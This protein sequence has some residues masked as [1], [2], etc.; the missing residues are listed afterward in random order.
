MSNLKSKRILVIGINFMPELTGIGKYTGE[1]VSWLADN[2]YDCSVVTAFPYY[3]YWKIQ[4][5]Y[6]AL[7]YKKETLE[8]G[9]VNV[10]RCPLYVPKNPTGIKRII[11]DASFFISAFLMVLYLLFKPANDYIFCAA[12][13]FHLG[14]LGLFY[15]LFKGGKMIY[16]I[17]DLQVDAAKDLNI[18]KSEKLMNTLFT[19]EKYILKKSDE[20]SSIS[21]GMIRKINKKTDKSVLFF[22]NWVD[23]HQ[24]YPLDNT[25]IKK[26]FGFSPTDKIVLYSG[27]IG[28]KQGL[29][30]IIYVANE[31]RAE[32]SIKFLIC[33]SGPYK[34]KLQNLA[35]ELNLENVQFYPLQPIETFNEFFNIADVHLVI[36]KANVSD[37]VMPS[38]LT[39]ILAVGGL[40]VVTS[41]PET[42]LYTEVDNHEMGILVKAEDREALIEGIRSAVADNNQ[43]L[44][45]NARSYAENYLSIDSVLPAFMRDLENPPA[46]KRTQINKLK[47]Q[48]DYKK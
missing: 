20:V 31:L 35:E 44:K 21:S 42:T 5:P 45:S 23:T 22:P 25:S 16:H 28:E 10:Y 8:K 27:S 41:N 33:G 1:M 19:A 36:Q 48:S 9:K 17:Q 29:E 13:P 37:L 38:K 3:P 15:R 18:I 26:K 39:T 32:R 40:A 46:P 34:K 2:G 6:K 30:N 43:S 7:L 24:F 14:F 11:H 4:S 12:P 47:L